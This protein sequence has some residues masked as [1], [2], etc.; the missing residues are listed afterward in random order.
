MRL[1][2][3]VL[4]GNKGKGRMNILEIE[5]FACGLSR[6]YGVARHQ[7]GDSD[8]PQ[9]RDCGRAAAAADRTGARCDAAES[10]C[11]A[12]RQYAVSGKTCWSCRKNRCEIARP[13]HRHGVSRA[14]DGA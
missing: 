6:Q 9:N 11:V 3:A 10:R 7:S 5:H 2:C 1:M 14:D 8:R 4:C 13:R 12:A